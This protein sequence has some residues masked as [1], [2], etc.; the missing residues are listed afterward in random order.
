MTGT[1]LDRIFVPTDF[2][3]IASHAMKY[4]SSLADRLGATL[5]VAYCDRFLPP[6]DYTA[7]VGAWDDTCL[8]ELK[9]RAEEQV[10]RDA[11]ANIDPAVPFDTL[12]RVAAPI[13]GITDQARQSGA[14]LIVMGTHGRT[15]F[16]RIIIG[17]V[18]EGVMRTAEVP[19][20]AVA[21]RSST[22]S[23]M[24]TIICPVIYNPQ[25]HEALTLAERIAPPDARFI[26]IRPA[27][28]DGCAHPGDDLLA[29]SAWVPQA[30]ANRFEVKM[31]GNGHMAKQIEFFAKSVHADLIVAAEPAPRS[32][33]DMLHGT[34]AER[35]VRHAACP[36]LT[37][38]ASAEI[39]A[40]RVGQE[41]E[42]TVL[43]WAHQ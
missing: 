23:S 31:F 38:N 39:V 26:L 18:T 14:A 7:T 25:C 24:K 2:S 19:V 42:R 43:M 12:V 33:A 27:P 35:L 30:I 5:T 16:R 21:P 40:A 3:E 10:Q 6:I 1:K 41:E 9:A 17:S 34:F 32:A 15:G 11:E 36:V 4:A 20:I 28:A 8:A 29:L 22:S 13:D 37:V